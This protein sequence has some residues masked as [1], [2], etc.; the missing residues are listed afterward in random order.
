MR[1]AV[2]F[3]LKPSQVSESDVDQWFKV[4]EN[5]RTGEDDFEKLFGTPTSLERDLLVLS[6]AVFA[7]DLTALRGKREEVTRNIDL[8]VPVVNYHALEGQRKE[9]ERILHFLSHDNW[10]L[11]FLPRPGEQDQFQPAADRRGKTLLFSGGLD[12]L[13]EAIDLLDE[14]GAADVQLASHITG[15]S[16]TRAAQTKLFDYL[17]DKYKD[18]GTI[19]RVALRTGR[20]NPSAN[21]NGDDVEDDEDDVDDF[22]DDPEISQRTRSFTFLTIAVLAARRRRMS[23]VLMIAENGQMAIHLPLSAGRIGAF[24]THTAHP[25]FIKDVEAYFNEIL[26]YPVTI[27]NPFVYKTKAEVVAKLAKDHQSIVA[28]SNSCWKSSRIGGKHCGDCIPCY[29]RRIALEFHGVKVD[30]WKRD[31]FAENFAKLKETDEGRRNL[32]E[33]AAFAQDFRQL[34]PSELYMKHCEL[35]SNDFDGDQVVEMYKRFAYETQQVVSR[36]PQLAHLL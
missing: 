2:F 7:T 35:Y 13:A 9:L 23:E 8:T 28:A 15:N 27:T 11:R 19:G 5:L 29:V 22:T 31:I 25:K 4:G 16:A 1:G 17:S 33:L 20:K 34:D 36:Y 12:S 26:Q 24:S 6:S 30:Q 10:S 18:T 32:T 21:K 3:D 14:F